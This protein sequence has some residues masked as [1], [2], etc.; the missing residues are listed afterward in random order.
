MTGTS[1]VYDTYSCPPGVAAYLGIR[2]ARTLTS[3]KSRT[4]CFQH[5]YV[6]QGVR[7]PKLVQ[8]RKLFLLFLW[9]S[10]SKLSRRS[11]ACRGSRTWS[12][13]R[14]LD[15]CC[16]KRFWRGSK[17]LNTCICS[18]PS[19]ALLCCLR[20]SSSFC[21]SCGVI[22]CQ[23]I[24]VHID[25]EGSDVRLLGRRSPARFRSWSKGW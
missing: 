22:S 6:P 10:P 11:P 3:S 23:S 25:R 14:D 18:R 24:L 1:R 21:S 7:K 4:T 19:I 16:I 2:R 15:S 9:C 8:F 5:F 17:G 20:L 12:L 13:L